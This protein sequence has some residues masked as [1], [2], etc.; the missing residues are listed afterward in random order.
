MLYFS[1]TDLKTKEKGKMPAEKVKESEKGG[2]EGKGEKITVTVESAHDQPT[3]DFDI[4]ARLLAFLW[5]LP[6]P[7]HRDQVYAAI[8]DQGSPEPL[9]LHGTVVRKIYKYFKLNYKIKI[10]IEIEFRFFSPFLNIYI[11]IRFNI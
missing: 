1:P 9:P 2:L 10:E 7:V 6:N 11:F 3:H 5:L 8:N 4:R